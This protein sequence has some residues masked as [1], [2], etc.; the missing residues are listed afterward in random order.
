MVLSFTKMH[1][2]GND[3][4]VFDAVNQ[5]DGDDK[6]LSAPHVGL[7]QF[8]MCDGSVQAITEHIDAVIYNAMGTRRGR[9]VID[10]RD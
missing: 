7:C 3:F 5:I 4:V 9:E 2:L 1:G 10:G 8:V 6:G